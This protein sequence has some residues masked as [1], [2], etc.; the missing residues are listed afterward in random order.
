M[1]GW[2]G[3][4][5]ALRRLVALLIDSAFPAE[6]PG[7]CLVLGQPGAATCC[8]QDPDFAEGSLRNRDTNWSAVVS[9]DCFCH[10]TTCW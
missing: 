8:P 7:N 4:S 6:D 1:G 10:S 5:E 9:A 2:S 3:N